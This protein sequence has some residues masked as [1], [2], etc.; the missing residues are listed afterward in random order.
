MNQ[1]FYACFIDLGLWW[2]GIN[3]EF[4]TIH[5]QGKRFTNMMKIS[6][7]NM[8]VLKRTLK[9]DFPYECRCGKL[10]NRLCSKTV[11]SGQAYVIC[12]ISLILVT[13]QYIR[14]IHIIDHI[15]AVAP[16]IER[17]PC[18]RLV[19]VRITAATD[20]CRYDRK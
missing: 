12:C 6:S 15:A 9:L 19:G 7:E 3:I 10:M 16:L 13:T 1:N 11:G 14:V 4:T 2:S 17:S 5:I 8:H 20:P 18:M